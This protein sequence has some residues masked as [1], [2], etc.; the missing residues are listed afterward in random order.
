M[1]PLYLKL[2]NTSCLVIGG[3][4]IA[5]RKTQSLL[6]A[7]A[8][9]TLISPDVTDALQ[10]LIDKKEIKYKN[11][12]FEKGDTRNYFLIIAAT[13]SRES[14][15]M[16]YREA[17]E[18]QKL[19]NCVDDPDYCNFYVPA[20]VN[21]G[22]L[23]IAISTEGKLPM[24]AGRLRKFFNSL[25]PENMG[26]TLDELGDMRKEIISEAGSDETR[27]KAM[28]QKQISPLIDSIMED[29]GK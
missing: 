13:N 8:D 11:R 27:K 16:V 29:I 18:S 19:I 12:V 21:R 14:N 2:E 22:N 1:Y 9:I 15:I 7:G 20:Q 25:L 10:I 24:L 23:K 4:G 17:S 5:E 3:G 6:E 28:F 26:D